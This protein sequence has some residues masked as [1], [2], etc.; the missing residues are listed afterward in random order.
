MAMPTAPPVQ[1]W[2]VAFPHDMK[3][4]FFSASI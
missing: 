3:L 4:T 1:G 2:W